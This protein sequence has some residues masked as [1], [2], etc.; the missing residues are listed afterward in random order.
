MQAQALNRIANG[1]WDR[2]SDAQAGSSSDDIWPKVMR[3]ISE[4]TD[5]DTD[6]STADVQDK[7]MNIAFLASDCESKE[8]LSRAYKA[9]SSKMDMKSKRSSYAWH[10]KVLKMDDGRC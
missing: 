5:N 4:L 9:A 2:G 6:S 8:N 3:F 7:L 1:S 10:G